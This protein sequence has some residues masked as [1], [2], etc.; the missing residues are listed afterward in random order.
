MNPFSISTI[1]CVVYTLTSCNYDYILM[2][3]EY[4]FHT[5]C[6]AQT[7]S[8]HVCEDLQ[9]VVSPDWRSGIRVKLDR[10][11]GIPGSHVLRDGREIRPKYEPVRTDERLHGG[12][13]GLV[14]AQRSVVIEGLEIVQDVIRS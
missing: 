14:R 13:S 4:P 3:L 12:K 5:A 2:V 8:F 6:R 11:F 7:V 1:I 9:D 10:L